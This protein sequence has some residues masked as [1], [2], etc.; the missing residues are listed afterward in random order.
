MTFYVLLILPLVF[1]P[2]LRYGSLDRR[3]AANGRSESRSMEHLDSLPISSPQQN[4]HTPHHLH[5][6]HSMSQYPA[7]VVHGHH[8]SPYV[9]MND[10][11][12]H[13]KI[14]H[15][16]NGDSVSGDDMVDGLILRNNL[17][18]HRSHSGPGI[19][20]HIQ[21]QSHHNKNYLHN[22]NNNH[23][24]SWDSSHSNNTIHRLVR[25]PS[26]RS[27]VETTFVGESMGNQENIPPLRPT[28]E[29][30]PLRATT[31]DYTDNHCHAPLKPTTSVNAADLPPRVPVNELIPLR[32]TKSSSELPPLRAT[33]L[34]SD[35][36]NTI[37]NTTITEEPLISLA[38]A[39]RSKKDRCKEWYETSLD[40]PGPGR[41]KKVQVTE[42]SKCSPNS[43]IIPSSQSSHNLS[44]S[45]LGSTSSG[46]GSVFQ[47]QTDGNESVNTSLSI[48]SPRNH[49]MITAGTFQPSRETSKP[50]EMADFYKY[51]VKYRKQSSSPSLTNGHSSGG[52]S[53]MSPVLPPRAQLL[54]SNSKLTPPSPGQIA[55]QSTP[56]PQQKGVYQPLTPLTCKPIEVLGNVACGEPEDPVGGSWESTP[57]HQAV[58]ATVT[59][60]RAATLV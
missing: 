55:Q 43:T 23:N 47:S 6:S 2:T 56:A 33:N 59:T 51:S 10:Q 30:L 48:E 46:S 40:S 5:T 27:Y 42:I 50:F 36:N 8:K 41:K 25:T 60:K 34:K 49:M 12:D 11:S 16:L 9:E 38:D 57:M 31:K 35:L 18:R 32:A 45:S 58:P 26:G 54:M 39:A 20:H 17:A 52:E 28:S 13:G 29:L 37:T 1:N 7:Y 53:P 15:A 24:M 3:R 14:N 4:S 22:M 21:H 19:P 44:T